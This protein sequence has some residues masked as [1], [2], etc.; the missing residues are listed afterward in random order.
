[1][2]LE[3]GAIGRRRVERGRLVAPLPARLRLLTGVLTN[4]VVL[5]LHRSRNGA[6]S[7]PAGISWSAPDLPVRRH[8]FALAAYFTRTFAV[9][10][11][12]GGLSVGA[13][14]TAIIPG[15]QVL[16]TSNRYTPFAIRG[17]LKQ[18]SERTTV[19][20]AAGNEIGILG[21]ED[22]Q[23]VE[24]EE[25]PQLVIDAVIA[26]EDQTF[27]ENPGVD[28]NGTIRAF[29][30]NATS[31]E[32]EQGG[33]TIS[34][35]LVKNRVLSSTRDLDRKVREMVLAYRLN[36]EYSKQEILEEYLNTVYFGEG[37]YGI[38]TAALRIIGKPLD[39]L[40][41][42]DA[43]LLAGLIAN[44]EGDNPFLAPEV[45]LQRRGQVLDEQVDQ[46]YL[47]PAE[48][49]F[50]KAGP[51]PA[52]RPA[53][54]DLRPQNFFVEEVQR[55]LLADERLGETERERRDTLLRG[56]LE[57]HSTLDPIAQVQAQDAVNRQL[58]NRPGF[59]AALFALEPE[60]GFV[61]AMVG[62]PGFERNQYNIA[63]S[64]PG[65]QAGSAWKIITL[66]AALDS[67]YSPND[68]VSGSSP[69]TVPS[70]QGYGDPG[71]IGRATT[72]NAEGGGG[73]MTIRR[74][75]TGSV[76][77]A[78]ARLSASVGYDRVVEIAHR[79]GIKQDLGRTG[80]DGNWY[81]ARTPVLTLGVFESTLLE[82]ATVMATI[83]NEGERRDPIFVER[84]VGP[85]G[86]TIFDDRERDGVRAISPEAASCEIDI[87][88][89]VVTG[90]TGTGA[91]LNPHVAIG[92]T[93]TTD[94]EADA[95]FVGAVPQLVAHVWYGSPE[96]DIPGA[97]FGGETP[98]AI[99]REFMS[100]YTAD[101]P[102]V[103]W[104]APSLNCVVRGARVTDLGRDTSRPVST[105]APAPPAFPPPA[106]TPVPAAP[107]PPP[108]VE[109]PPA[110]VP[111]AL[112]PT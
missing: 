38:K 60:T 7:A 3:L 28:L 88:R 25:V 109:P 52:V 45:A 61:R 68:T 14:L 100:A 72:R 2:R 75:T 76:N 69:C 105:P 65:Q 49:E 66:A 24:L 103:P 71:K 104:P 108:V 54:V 86:Q 39:Q 62:G 95:N 10:L 89:G 84:V 97:G 46:E 57:V 1:M 21:L 12:V 59:T 41:I 9:I 26:A 47:T 98:A 102:V 107:P 43:A 31:G 34:Q 40:D 19:Y 4:A 99:W 37:S 101:K 85:D 20:D 13:L 110:T 18:L 70:G 16:A 74:A 30:E 82:M 27:W 51:L 33:S 77:C 79:L 80:E 22:R 63:T 23:P 67:G 81:P 29:I 96:G 8:G 6:T 91:R 58:P 112:P 48:A 50:A 56:G 111:A 73:T 11:V 17:A 36:E 42:G 5:P 55:R 44:P 83:V 35:Q 78:Y 106:T 15:A 53:P 64:P 94:R 90:G 92:K 93:G 87:L 32:I